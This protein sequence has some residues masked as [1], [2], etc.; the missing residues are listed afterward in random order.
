MIGK[1]LIVKT[2]GISQI[3]FLMQTNVLDPA[4][5]KS[6]NSTLFKFIW[7]KHFNSAKAPERIRRDIATLPIKL[8]GLGMLDL[9]ELDDSI[10]LR[11][12]GRLKTSKHPV[13]VQLRNKINHSNY[14]APTCSVTSDQYLTRSLR[15]L[16]EARKKGIQDAMLMGN[17]TL[18][19]LL[20]SIPIK[21]L[22][23]RHGRNSLIYF[24]IRRTGKF[25]IGDLTLLDFSSIERFVTD[26]KDLGTRIKSALMTRDWAQPN[27][28]DNWTIPGKGKLLNL[29][30][31]TSKDLR[32]IVYSKTPLCIFKNGSLFTT[33]ESINYFSK[34]S[35]LTSVAHRNILLRTLHGDI[36]TNERLH[37]FRLRNDP[38]C[39]RCDGVETLEHR[40]NECPKVI[41]LIRLLTTKTD[42]LGNRQ[43]RNA[44]EIRDKLIA[45]YRDIDEATL[46]LHAEI[47]KIVNSNSILDSPEQIINRAIKLIISRDKNKEVGNKLK[48]FI[49]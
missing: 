47:L 33:N 45:N 10:K 8:G 42:R 26:Y 5:I 27:E 19:G 44:H 43:E 13:L 36:Y 34:L 1:I 18:N 7:N 32:L 11:S 24:N 16:G 14:L 17:R 31:L 15:V 6:F 23:N 25:R 20:K 28:A 37:R 21:A 48:S 35:K 38:F 4:D 29:I 30:P 3:T 41:N 12:L 40:L 9:N 39:S 22:L 46:T 49:Q 2:F